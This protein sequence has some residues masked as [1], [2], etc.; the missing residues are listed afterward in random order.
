MGI[1]NIIFI[2]VLAAAIYFFIRNILKI[3]YN[4]NLGKDIDIS[5]NRKLR[6]KTMAK[7]AL[8]QSKMTVRPV[9]GLLHIVVYAGF[10]LI[11]IEVTSNLE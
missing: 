10:I 2:I 9:A 6:W 8:G 3:S 4:I 5:D 1:A 7:V 11:N